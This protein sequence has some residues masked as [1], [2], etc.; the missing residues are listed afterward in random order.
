ME[1]KEK[2]ELEE[3]FIAFIVYEEQLRWNISISDKKLEKEQ[4]EDLYEKVV[5]YAEAIPEY[6]MREYEYIPETITADIN[7]ALSNKEFLD[8]FSEFAESLCQ[9]ADDT[10][11]EDL[12]EMSEE[13]L[14]DI[15]QALLN[16]QP[17]YLN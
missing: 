3:I 15:N 12:L 17:E 8:S 5:Y 1:Q 11:D 16:S 4:L 10:G 7:D 2:I 13:L 6:L 14:T 9:F